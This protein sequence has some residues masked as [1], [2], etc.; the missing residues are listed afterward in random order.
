[1]LFKIKEIE[2]DG[3]VSLGLVNAKWKPNQDVGGVRGH[4]WTLTDC[5]STYHG[6]VAPV[7]AGYCMPFYAN[8]EVGLILDRTEGTIRYSINGEEKEI[9]FTSED[10]KADELYPVASLS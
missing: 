5:G 6:Q 7:T 3:F 4:G 10:L 1:M 9:A 2:T 8:D